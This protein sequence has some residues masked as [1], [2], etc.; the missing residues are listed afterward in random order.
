MAALLLALGLAAATSGV[1]LLAGP[2]AALI[3]G[4]LILAAAGLLLPDRQKTGD[5]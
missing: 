5:E 1:F 2:G 4:G 3:V